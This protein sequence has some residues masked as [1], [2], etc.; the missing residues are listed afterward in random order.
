MR[1]SGAKEGKKN[2]LVVMSTGRRVTEQYLLEA[3]NF[4]LPNDVTNLSQIYSIKMLL[5]CNLGKY[6]ANI[7]V[8]TQL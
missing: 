2:L 1:H 6:G 7:N 3:F 8:T 4:S 5:P